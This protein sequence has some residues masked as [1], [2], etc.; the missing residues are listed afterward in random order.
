MKHRRHTK[1][2]SRHASARRALMRTLTSQLLRHG[3][4]QTT[5]AKARALVAHVEPLIAQG[6]HNLTLH[7][8]RL[9]LRQLARK[10]DLD[11]LLATA[12]AAKERRSGWLRTSRLPA[13]VGDA[14]EMSRVEIIEQ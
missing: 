7:R 13:R 12:K 2:L 6:K 4:I 10:E 3:A 9:L 14:A 5:R 8:R 1:R 11:A